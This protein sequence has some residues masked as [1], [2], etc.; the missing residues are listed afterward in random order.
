MPTTP[1]FALPYPAPTA[2][3]DVPYDVQQL[4]QQVEAI[5]QTL[6]VAQLSDATY[7]KAAAAVTTETVIDKFSIAAAGYN[8]RA[9]VA[10]NAYCVAG[11][12]II[13]ADYILY[14]SLN[15]GAF[16]QIGYGRKSL[17]VSL[18]DHWSVTGKIDIPSGQTCVIE[19]RVNR[20]SGSGTLTTSVSNALTN[21]NVLLLRR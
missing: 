21:T 13:Q 7:P 20:F 1:T 11:T 9:L 16:A 14:A 6:A 19:A 8:R 12:A 5:A 3:P 17:S 4:A 10:G 15:G 18:P 2:A